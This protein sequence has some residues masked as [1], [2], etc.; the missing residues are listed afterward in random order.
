M[1]FKKRTLSAV[2]VLMMLFSAIPSVFASN[3]ELSGDGSSTNPYIIE[4][5]ADLI[6]FCEMV[7]S[8]DSADYCAK[9]ACDIT[10]T[11][12]WIPFSSKSGN[13]TTA[14][15]GTF[16]G[17]GNKISGLTINSTTSNT[18]LFKFIDGATIKNLRVEGTVTSTNNYVGGIVGKIRQGKIENCSFEGNV[19]STKSGANVGGIAGYI[20]TRDMTTS[21]IGCV[22]RASV[23]GGAVGGITGYST[24]SSISDC[25]NTGNITGTS[26]NGG[27][28]GNLQGKSTV[29]NCYSIGNL[30]GGTKIG[31]ICGFNGT[32]VEN[33][34]YTTVVCGEGA[35]TVT[36]CE[37][38]S[39]PSGLSEKL[40]SAFAED[41]DLIN[42]GYP[43]LTWESGTAPA[44]KNPSVKISGNSLIT[45]NNSGTPAFT[46]LTATAENIDDDV[47]FLWSV[48]KG[49]D[50]IHLQAPE[51]ADET[52][53][54]MMV[55]ADKAGK[56]T[57][58][59]STEDGEYSDSIDISVLPFVTTVEIDG[60]TAVGRTVKAKV[61]IL[62]GDEY[63]YDSFPEL[64]FQWKYLSN[65]DYTSGNT[66]Y[67]SYSD[68]S[69]A[70]EREFTITSDM[71]GDYL[72]FSVICGSEAKSP[73][74][75]VKIASAADGFAAED[76]DAL[77]I[78]TTDIKS[79][80][81]ITLP[82][83]GKNGS[84]ISWESSDGSIID[85]ANGRVTPPSNGISD[86]RLTASIKYSDDSAVK[87]RVFTVRVYSEAEA[88]KE[89]ND[90]L[91]QL[92]SV[93]NGLGSYKLV[94]VYGEDT[95]IIDMLKSDINRDDI[96]VSIK[97]TKEIYGGADIKSDGTVGYY[98][99]N[100]NE[101]ASV[102]FG[103]FNVTFTLAIDDAQK[104]FTVPVIVYHDADKVKDI[105]RKEIISE[106]TLSADG[107]I[108]AESDLTLP[109]IAADK[110][111]TLISWTSSNE[112]ILRISNENQQT[113]DT[114]FN[115][116]VGKVNRGVKDEK[117][118]LTALYTYQ[119]TNDVTSS[120]K[121]ITLAMTYEVTVKALDSEGIAAKR[122]EL[123]AK[124]EAG[125]ESAGLRDAVSGEKLTD[126][127]G[128]YIT[129]NDILFPTTSDF[130]VDGKYTPE[131][132]T[133]DNSDVI[134]TYDV[135]NAARVQVIRPAPGKGDAVARVT[136]SLSE[137]GTGISA[138][139]TFKVCVKALT[140]EE[141]TA[142]KAL[143]QR[144]KDAYF[145]GIK[146]NNTS[147]NNISQNLSAFCEVYEKDGELVWVR[148]NADAVNHGIVPVS[149]KNWEELEAWRLFKSSNPSVISHENLLVTMKKNAKSVTV[150][151]ALSSE[152]LG[153]YGELYIS[154]PEKYAD[155]KELADL[156]YQEVSA[157]L[158]VRG[159]ST[160]KYDIPL[161]SVETISV[162]FTLN[163]P[164]DTFIS[165]VTL[166]DLAETS[167]AYDVFKKVLKDNG[168]TY[169]SKGTGYGVYITSV[170]TPNGETVAE[171]SYGKNSGWM[172]KINGYFADV[173]MTACGLNDGDSIEVFYS[174][175]YMQEDY[176]KPGDSDNDTTGGGSSSG[177]SSYKKDDNTDKGT[178]N[179]TDS[180][181]AVRIIDIKGHWAEKE[182]IEICK[183]G[184]LKG[185][186]NNNFEPDSPLTRAM[187]VTILHR[188]ENEP[189]ASAVKFTDVKDGEWYRAAVAWAAENGI[190][191][192]VSETKFA[193]DESI[194]REQ[195]AVM[196][197]RYAN[198][199]KIDT[200]LQSEITFDY[201][202]ADRID[203]Y[204]ADALRWI[205][206]NKIMYGKT[207]STINPKDGATR[208]EIAVILLR[209][210]TKNNI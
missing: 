66:S 210:L 94:P 108:T 170:T 132:I 157:D 182:I 58:T 199:K 97:S 55:Y 187:L 33:C 201:S 191:N 192:G 1:N 51:N 136:V 74:R 80:G 59:V 84:V 154:D 4:D 18:G 32:S 110:K 7:N 17:Q 95:N 93:I 96:S 131:S 208:A 3:G 111:W 156:Y 120:E 184:I 195:L 86:I 91:T 41:S 63:D 205:S 115:P 177:G 38:I 189:E 82:S 102:H 172:Y 90:K 81:Y 14:Y 42:G 163:G 147:A 209:F 34:Y 22:N 128:S 118:E 165:E 162:S 39:S 6:K 200:T 161:A 100:P 153:R 123:A 15:K 85:P 73:S 76:A 26:N 141:I 9:L 135:N 53:G 148:A 105:M 173:A 203:E 130:G 134:F 47:K 183:R 206:E 126:I 72:S 155:Y 77:K 113:A 202:D 31:D 146:G 101:E 198:Y 54:K 30:I 133:S 11:S 52:N 137:K 149:L 196:L 122:A 62:G 169:N 207:E 75:P 43:I 65:D 143:M 10:L 21:V 40:G 68:I 178:E 167:T 197:Y 45:M 138:E 99:K 13:I 89:R 29:T 103:S 140:E 124:L 20:G 64:K 176:S 152:T 185:T 23:S 56:A 109:K 5:S 175:D 145:D 166:S 121:P 2:L 190:V 69:G 188:L 87:T 112:D 60:N 16:D 107:K 116:Y 194:T 19:S 106:T 8:V 24:A 61:N 127:N 71:E 142:E 168:Y 44:P 174:K 129:A 164:D 57:V 12:D 35:G 88:E 92:E 48:T 181:A 125:F 79:E 159:T 50:I 139:K 36:N 150:S 49:E 70:T 98:F 144:V 83:A 67:S 204:A 46:Q 186:D 117:V 78:D 171:F 179:N 160:G 193:P 25:Y 158:T 28:V 104:D 114:L 151:S 119:Y 180:T 27:I 37:Q